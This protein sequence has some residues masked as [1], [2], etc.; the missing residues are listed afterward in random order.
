[1][2]IIT[3]LLTRL[4]TTL[5][6]SVALWGCAGAPTTNLAPE[7]YPAA[8]LAE[9]IKMRA[10]FTHTTQPFEISG[11]EQVWEV[12]VG[13][14]RRDE[15]IEVNR[16]FC[17]VDSRKSELR[18]YRKCSDTEPTVHIQWV[19]L[20][21]DGTEAGRYVYDALKQDANSQS[22]TAYQIG[23]GA[24]TSQPAGRYKLAVTVL[25]DLMELD[26][27]DPHI[28]IGKPFFRRR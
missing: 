11:P 8:L 3:T 25:R 22:S 18:K 27:T 16:F 19:L 9:P 7:L 4:L 24:F 15:K 10:G 14:T 1:M 26:I 5:Q 13:F 6:F 2:K 21:P 20:L 17:L 23:L 12:S 28:V